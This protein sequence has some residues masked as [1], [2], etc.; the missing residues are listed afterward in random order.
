MPNAI[1]TAMRLLLVVALDMGAVGL[2]LFQHYVHHDTGAALACFMGLALA[3]WIVAP[4]KQTWRALAAEVQ[5]R[6][7]E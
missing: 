3:S 2:A 4:D 6:K 1:N 5:R 7:Q